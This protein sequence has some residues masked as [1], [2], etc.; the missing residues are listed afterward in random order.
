[1]KQKNRVGINISAN[2]F[3]QK[4]H[5]KVF[6]DGTESV[7]TLCLFC[8]HV[9]PMTFRLVSLAWECEHCGHLFY[10]KLWIIKPSPKKRKVGVESVET[11]RELS[12]A[13]REFLDWIYRALGQPAPQQRLSA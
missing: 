2:Q 6:P 3:P 1:M 7:K 4:E 13:A 12:A 5:K 9:G 11:V 8:R 10:A